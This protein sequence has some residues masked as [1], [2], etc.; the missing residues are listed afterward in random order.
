MDSSLDKPSWLN[1]VNLG[2]ETLFSYI[3]DINQEN[4]VQDDW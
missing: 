3:F 4:N 2:P 1:L